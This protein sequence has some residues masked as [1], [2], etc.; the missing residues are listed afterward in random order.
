MCRSHSTVREILGTIL[1]DTKWA[2]VTDMEAGL[3][4]LKRG[5]IRHV[6]TML[7]VI[8]PYF[9]SLEMGQRSRQLAQELGIP[10]LAFVAN[11]VRNSQD[12]K[13]IEDYCKQH[14]MELTAIIPH[15]DKILEAD[16]HGKAPLDHSA[17]S[18]AIKALEALAGK[19][20]SMEAA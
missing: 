16:Q 8:E 3:E 20:I 18:E 2:A 9:K 17:D 6:G 12:Q 11:K 7:I 5:T 13:I 4:H 10:R 15:D 14:D 1:E 19:I